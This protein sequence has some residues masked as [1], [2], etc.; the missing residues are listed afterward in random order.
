MGWFGKT[1]KNDLLEVANAPYKSTLKFEE[2]FVCDPAAKHMGF[3]SWDGSSTPL[4]P[5]PQYIF[6]P[7]RNLQSVMV[8]T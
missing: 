3:K 6:L 5:K 1:G 2:M 7:V 8:L 4:F